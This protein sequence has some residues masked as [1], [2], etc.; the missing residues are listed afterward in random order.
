MPPI[1]PL[2]ESVECVARDAD[3]DLFGVASVDRFAAVY[4]R[5]RP[6]AH[7]P[8]ARCA[9][10]LAMRYPSAMYELAGKTPAESF[11]SLDSYESM[12]MRDM[13]MVAAMDVTRFLESRGFLAIPMQITHFRVHPY[14]DI[15]DSWT[16]DFDHAVCAVAAGLG[17]LGLHGVPITPRYGTRQM[18]ISV[19]TEAPLAAD[20]LYRGEP[21]CD[22]CMACATHCHMQAFDPAKR[23]EVAIGDRTFAVLDKDVWRCMWSRR[24]MLNAEAGPKL[25]GLDVTVDPPSD[26]PITEADVQAALGEKGR[27]GGLQTWYT[28]ADRAC[29]RVCVPPH[30]RAAPRP[31]VPAG[32]AA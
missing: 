5:M 28:Y 4:P 9:I 29:E 7:L 25:G 13:L 6:E 1:D 2:R 26:R 19:V 31:A 3:I 20:P 14:K 15:P 32:G 11:M 22:G 21:L 10:S 16:R 30:L 24:F 27:K 12:H 8:S 18:F 23:H 17:E